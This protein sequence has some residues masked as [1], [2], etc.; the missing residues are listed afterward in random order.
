MR[1]IIRAKTCVSAWLQAVQHLRVKTDW[2]DYNLVLEIKEPLSLPP[3]EKRISEEV[4]HFLIDHKKQPLSTVINT[5]FPASLYAK[6]GSSNIFKEYTAIREDM[7]S[8]PQR[9]WGTYFLRMI[10]KVDP[11]GKEKPVNPLENLIDKLK[12]EI[13]TRAPKRAR[14]E[15]NLIDVFADIPIYDSVIDKGH[16]MGGPCLSHLSF[17]L[18]EDRTLLLTALYR[19]HYYIERA[20]GNFFGLAL[21]QDF[22]A[23]EAGLKTGALVCHS[24]MAVLDKDKIGKTAVKKLI[25]DCQ[26]LSPEEEQITVSSE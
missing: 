23:R 19:S 3:N 18:K 25:D 24:T 9:R 7:R 2:R 5:I 4:N 26:K 12:K 14:Y 20:L 15:L 11:S 16:S 13:K 21:L 1:D 6:K 17:K 8:H 22:V 10:H